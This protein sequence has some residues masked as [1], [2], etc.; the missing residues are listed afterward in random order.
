[1]TQNTNTAAA[2]AVRVIRNGM[3]LSRVSVKTGALLGSMMY[4]TWD[5]YYTVTNAALGRSIRTTDRNRAHY[6]LALCV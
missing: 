1:M 3:D 5:G 4:N 6:A 2:A